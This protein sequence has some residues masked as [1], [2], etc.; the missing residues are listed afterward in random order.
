[1]A[2][3]L[4]LSIIAVA[5]IISF[6]ALGILYDFYSL[7]WYESVFVVALCCMYWSSL[8]GLAKYLLQRDINGNWATKISLV[9]NLSFGVYLIHILI[10][11]NWLWKTEMICGINNY[12][13]QTL[14]VAI[15]TIFLSA[16]ALVSKTAVATWIIG[17]RKQKI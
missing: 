3:S 9:S 6:K 10:M 5:A 2:V 16:C 11:R 12:M 13:L 8:K 7:F 4:S 15:L 17:Y 1:M 14:V